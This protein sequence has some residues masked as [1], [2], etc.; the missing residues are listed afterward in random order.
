[1]FTLSPEHWRQV[2][3]YLDEALE[4][5]PAERK[6]WL[7]TLDQKD[8]SLASVLRSLLD[9]QERIREE[10]FLEGAPSPP[11]AGLAGQKI[12]AYTL[13]SQI[14]QGGMGAVWLAKRSDGRFERQAAVKFVNIALAGTATEERFKREG[15][16]LGR[17]SHPHIA[18][19]LD[20]G[21][22]STGQ[23]YLILEYIDG[24]AI[25]EYCEERRLSVEERVR[26][27]LDV[28]AAVAHAHT[29]LIVHRDIKPSNV[30]VTKDGKVK[31]LDFGIAKLLEGEE[32]G[33][34]ATLLTHEGGS[35]LTPQ[36]AAPEQLTAQPV[37]TATDVYALGVL[38]F[39]LLT[40][41]HPAGAGLRSPAELLKA[42]L[43]REAPRMSEVVRRSGVEAEKTAVSRS[44]TP[45]RLSRQLAGDLDTIVA[46]ALKKDPGERYPSVITLADDLQRYLRQEP[47]SSRP[48]TLAYRAAK[49][50]R[51]NRM[52]VMLS[53][54][55]LVALIG[56]ITGILVQGRAARRERDAALRERDRADRIAE[57][58]TGIFK[59]SDPSEK[60]GGTVTAAQL[61]D[62][63]E[64]EITTGLAKE[65][66]VQVSLMHV[67]GRAYMYQGLFAR[68]QSVF[69]RSIKIS[70][71]AGQQNSRETMNTMHDLAWA[72]LQQGKKAEAESLERKL[73]E[74]QQRLLGTD[75]ADTLATES[76]LG[77][78][79]AEE[80]NTVEG[81]RL[82]QDV[83]EKQKRVLGP[84]AHYTLVT[85]D[86]LAIMLAENH[87]PAEAEKLQQEALAIHMRVEGAENFSTIHAM[88]NLG[89][90]QRD[91]GR[92]EDA[93]KSMYRA[94]E[95][96]NRVLGPDQP[97]TAVTKYDLATIC[98]RDG[99]ADEAFAFLSQAVDHGLP[100]FMALDL[101]K[102]PL[103]TPLH[104]DARFAALVA[105]ANERATAA[106]G[107]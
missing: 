42:V 82:N 66:E 4:M 77:Y 47:I 102:D 18:E 12:G 59:A 67:I 49:F 43:E 6:A 10:G 58:M 73:L 55:A 46:K 74:R 84:E 32:Q 105:H 1:M 29:N 14:G 101:S 64:K 31:L 62:Q 56:G 44:T 33:G 28:L 36:Y 26:L 60:V 61:L 65:P 76:E 38:L 86:N 8:P 78:T 68:A 45:E 51:R 48:D 20:A 25:D 11:S 16:I 99:K 30:L 70:E 35:A 80:G 95:I 53:T 21:I 79:L 103:L 104:G 69:E 50:V 34:A 63:G 37:T 40:G 24:T 75:H 52:A 57:F 71:T 41:Q 5:E 100:P 106:K 89:E 88:L 19:L 17:L 81:V 7:L 90:F 107:N 98:A 91:S 94:L 2:S 83:L 87:Q 54:L 15:S 96:E 22:A 27:F 97:E 3:P 85:M 13:I 9:E 93:R 23:P 39:V 72:L 92:E